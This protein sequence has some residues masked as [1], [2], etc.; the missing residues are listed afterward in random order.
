MNT[1]SEKNTFN[2]ST[3]HFDNSTIKMKILPDEIQFFNNG[4]EFLKYAEDHVVIHGKEIINKDGITCRI[5]LK[6]YVFHIKDSKLLDI[7]DDDNED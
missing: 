4:I 1:Y 7:T 6:N 2:S 3:L 5:H